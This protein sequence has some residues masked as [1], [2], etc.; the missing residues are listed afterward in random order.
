M[1]PMRIISLSP[2][3]GRTWC[4]PRGGQ[5]SSEKVTILKELMLSCS[6]TLFSIVFLFTTGATP[7]PDSALML[8][9]QIPCIFWSMLP[10]GESVLC[11]CVCVGTSGLFDTWRCNRMLGRSGRSS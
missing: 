9:G 10:H 4:G 7:A 5:N 1:F 11:R 2:G 8:I 6:E 3:D